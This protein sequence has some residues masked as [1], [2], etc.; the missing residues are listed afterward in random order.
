MRRALYP[1]ILALILATMAACSGEKPF[2]ITGELSD[3]ANTNLYVK[4]Y[5]GKALNTLITAAREGKFGAQGFADEPTVVRVLDK[6][7][8]LLALVFVRNGDEINVTIDRTSL[9]SGN[10]TGNEVNDSLTAFLNANAKTMD[11]GDAKEINALVS[12]YIKDNPNAIASAILLGYVYDASIDPAETADLLTSLGEQAQLP[13]VIGQLT[14]QAQRFASSTALGKIADFKYLKAGCDSALTFK[15]A[16]KEASLL[17]FSDDRIARES[18]VPD[19]KELYKDAGASKLQI[20]DIVIANDTTAMKGITRLDSAKWTQAWTPGGLLSDQLS[21]LGV[22]ALPY[23]IVADSAGQ[24]T[25]RG[26]S[27]DDARKAVEKLTK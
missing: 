4:Y 1:V 15:A 14:I 3:G 22:P 18:I 9:A 16:D 20:V 12:K 5:N 25:Y 23:Y 26:K 24:Q 2:K 8:K 10:V 13:Y 21:P 6:D 19:L 17:V 27:I 7:D 11:S